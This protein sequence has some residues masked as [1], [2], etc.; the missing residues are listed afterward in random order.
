MRLSIKKFIDEYNYSQFASFVTLLGWS[1]DSEYG[2]IFT[3]WHKSQDEHDENEIVLPKTREIKKLEQTLIDALS[4]MSAYYK[5]DIDE[6]INEYL[7]K[8]NDK[9]K[10]QI[11]SE[12]TKNGL[13]PLSEGVRLIENSKE[14]IVS[15]VMATRRKKKNYIGQRPDFI[16]ELLDKVEMGQTEEGSYII[17]L[18]VPNSIYSDDDLPLIEEESFS[19]RA[20]NNLQIAAKE[21]IK[22]VDDY[23]TNEDLAVFD[24]GVDKYISSNMCYAIAE[25]SSDG[26]SDISII[27]EKSNGLERDKE[28]NEVKIAKEKVPIIRLFGDYYRKKLIEE[29][30]EIKGIVTKLHQEPGQLGGEISLTAIID[31]KLKRIKIMLDELNYVIA[32]QAHRGK[33]EL[34]CRGTLIQRDRFTLLQNIS[35]VLLGNPING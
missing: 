20:V 1:K 26:K 10:F 13:I 19:R 25:M 23:I 31:D 8:K 6:I 29:D 35:S 34:I 3:V 15:S 28:I 17:N 5:K 21:I 9:L 30:Y 27:V 4:N 12:M 33:L 7:N 14:L 2:E 11:K 24:D 18:F 16:N 32:I 22:L